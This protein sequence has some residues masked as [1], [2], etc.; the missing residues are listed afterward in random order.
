MA[1]KLNQIIAIEKGIKS[2]HQKEIT[3]LHRMS[4]QPTLFNGFTKSYRP[5]DEEGDRFPEE[6]NKVQERVANMLSKASRSFS[7]LM[8]TTATKDIAN[9]AARADVVVND[10]VLIPDAPATFLLFLEKQLNDVHTFVS[11]LPE[12]DEAEEWVEDGASGLQRTAPFETQKTKKVQEPVVLYDAT[13]EHPAQTQIVTKDVVAGYWTN[14]KLSGAISKTRKQE[15]LRRVVTLQ[16][17]VKFAREE[18]NSIEV[19][20]QKVGQDV[21]DYL[22]A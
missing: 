16:Q 9:T 18:A 15:I 19:E 14:T 8:D 1:P 5:K 11:D 12:L 17:A 22:F 3:S 20:K 4:G 7:E 2:R 13:K 6:R 21:M 10:D